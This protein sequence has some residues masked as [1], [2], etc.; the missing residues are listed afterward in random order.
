MNHIEEIELHEYLDNE[1]SPLRRAAV[2][3]HLA[4]CADCRRQLTD[5]RTLFSVIES[6]PDEAPLHDLSPAVV[7]ALQ[8]N[9]D[10][11]PSPWWL[12]TGQVMVAGLALAFVW[13]FLAQAVEPLI[14]LQIAH[15]F[16]AG[17][18][19]LLVE[20]QKVLQNSTAE[21]E[22]WRNLTEGDWLPMLSPAA[23]TALLAVAALLWLG[24]TRWGMIN[25]ND[26][27]GDWI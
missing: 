15:S 16:V 25:R 13:G 19:T 27:N 2:D 4:A 11:L 5:L 10:P 21:L 9:G 12:L 3:D 24:G 7:A 14:N 23:W 17:W 26:R 18:R 6:I 1:L 20:W 8:Q 22:Q